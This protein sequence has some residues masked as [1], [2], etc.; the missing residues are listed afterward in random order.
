MALERNVKKKPA[1]TADRRNVWLLILTTLL[2]VVSVVL[3]TPPNEKINQG[4]DIQGGLSVVLTRSP[5]TVR[6]SP[7]RTWR[8]PAPS[9]RA[10]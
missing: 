10:A 1:R 3:F 5:R 2:I 6:R 9:S 7:P 8:S 4:L